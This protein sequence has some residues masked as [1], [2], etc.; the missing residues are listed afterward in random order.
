MMVVVVV[1]MIAFPL[2]LATFFLVN[3]IMSTACSHEGG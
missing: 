1:V 2:A 3:L